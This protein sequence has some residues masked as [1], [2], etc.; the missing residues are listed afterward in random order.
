MKKGMRIM[1]SRTRILLI[2]T[3]IVVLSISGC[4]EKQELTFVSD[5]EQTNQEE[6]ILTSEE[7]ETS[8]EENT[9]E[10]IFI[11]QKESII[12]ENMEVNCNTN[13]V[14]FLP[15]A[16][17]T[18]VIRS[19][20]PG[21]E[22]F[23]V[24]TNKK[25]VFKGQLSEAVVSQSAGETVYIG[26]FSE[27]C[28]PGVYYILAADGSVSYP[29]IIGEDIYDELLK[30]SFR[31]LYTQRCGMELTSELAGDFAHP[32]CHNTEAVVYGTNQK[33]DVSGGW[34]DAGDYGRYVVSGVETV[35][36]LFL[37]YEDFPDIWNGENAD[38]FDIPESGNG[39]PDILDEA[40]HELDWLLKMQDEACGG[41]YHKVTCRDFPGFVM[42]QE[43][44]GELVLAPIS[45][46]A[47]AD[48]A[49][50]MAKS[51][52]IYKDIDAAFAD[53]CLKASLK[54]WDYLE[55][56]QDYTG[57]HNPGD[58][59]TGEYPDGQNQDERFWASV[60]LYSVTKD[61]KYKVFMEGILEQSVFHG[62]GWA[63]MGSYGNIEYVRAD[64]KNPTYTDK[65][66]MDISIKANQL[67]DNA[68][69]DG[70]L[71]SLGNDF[72]WG[73]NMV[74]SN[75]ARQLLL[76]EE[77]YNNN[78]YED[79]AYDQ[80]NYLLGQNS[81]SYC[82]VTGYGSLFPNYPHHRT[83]MATGKVYKGM[84]IG[85]PNSALEDP[86]VQSTLSGVPAAKCYADSDQS[87]ST[88]EFTI[89]WNASFVYL[90]SSQI[91]EN[92]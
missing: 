29:F 13:Q 16:R 1:H 5:E 32:V 60:E 69:R 25:E 44:T 56:T 19:D 30:D 66:K 22:F 53:K 15:N 31:M 45:T 52:R 17:K 38:A 61:D 42:P 89:Y 84:V 35:A 59:L 85:G 68:N 71:V 39:I 36:D 46:T 64:W 83:S 33:K 80:L 79:C 11:K 21:S 58:I 50:I 23:V 78:V 47:T 73:S 51:S 87:Y 37:S 24:D 41:V 81:L 92:K 12:T 2:V 49:A 86:F 55:K 62:F 88:N 72:V 90:L 74:V 18:V 57:F 75:N 70:Y 67:I 54:A 6:V 9:F 76:A 28:I 40:K 7:E 65:I 43:E 3:L 8:T 77:L 48:F 27:L 91:S 63:N 82:F 34:H 26:D 4:G 10:E 14:G 20:N